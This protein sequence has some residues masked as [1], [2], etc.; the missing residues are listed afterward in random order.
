MP[1]RLPVIQSST[2][3]DEL[4]ASRPRWH[5]VGIGAGLTLTLWAPLVLVV[6]P[7][8]VRLSARVLGRPVD[9][10]ASP[11]TRLSPRE[12]SIV[13]ALSA[14]PLLLAFALAA[15]GAGALVGR[16]GGRAGPPQAALGAALAAA[17][18]T[19][20]ALAARIGISG[21]SAVAGLVALAL[22]GGL[23]GSLGGSFG[24]RK[25]PC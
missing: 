25:R 4:A 17:L 5:W 14:A 15:F 23:G 3:E 24:F 9:D 19:G 6:A 7:L 11:A 16:F 8:G 18:A 22:A 12:L 2:A 13:G 21:I 10:F 1:R 20:A